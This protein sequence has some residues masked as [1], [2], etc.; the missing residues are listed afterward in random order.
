MVRHSCW[1]RS[2]AVTPGSGTSL[3]M[4]A[5][6]ETS[7]ARRCARSGNE[8]SRSSSGPTTPKASR[9]CPDAGSSSGPLHGSAAT[10]ASPRTSGKPSPRQPHGCSSPQSSSSHAASQEDEIY[11]DNFESDSERLP[12]RLADDR[13]S[14][15]S[16]PVAPSDRVRRSVPCPA[17]I[18]PLQRDSSYVTCLFTRRFWRAATR[19]FPGFA[20]SRK[21]GLASPLPD[22]FVPLAS[23]FRF[24]AQAPSSATARQYPQRGKA[25][26][27]SMAAGLI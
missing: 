14:D 13:I 25:L 11:R 9:Y 20:G 18:R 27:A 23:P 16:G 21:S 3:P 8:R 6:P 5:M 17:R 10:A 22:Q 7:C 12:K 1:Q 19:G 26:A 15:T 4:V 2:Y 24:A